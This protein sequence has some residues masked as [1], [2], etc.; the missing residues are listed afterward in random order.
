MAN[1]GSR[2]DKNLSS[3]KSELGIIVRQALHAAPP[4]LD[5]AVI[6]GKR[7]A[8]EQQ[9]LY[10]KGRSRP[11]AL[12]II[13]PEKVVTHCDGYGKRSAHQDGDALDIVAYVEGKPSWNETANAAVAAYMIGFAAARGVKLTGGVK[14][15][16]DYGH[17]QLEA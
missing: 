4:W 16:W 17:L 11:D 7:T 15:G 14:W 2:S 9:E 1:I 5:F 8:K 10:A 3:V 6:C 13:E 12:Y